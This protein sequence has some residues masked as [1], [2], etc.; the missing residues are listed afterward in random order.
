MEMKPNTLMYDHIHPLYW[1]YIYLFKPETP[2]R[3]DI[4]EN[5][6]LK[7]SILMK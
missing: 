1:S 7:E 5:L 4:L 6:K 3:R 2:E